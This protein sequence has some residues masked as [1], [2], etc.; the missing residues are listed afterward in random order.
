M[1]G[2][3]KESEHQHPKSIELPPHDVFKNLHNVKRF[4]VDIGQFIFFNICFIMFHVY[5]CVH[6]YACMHVYMHACMCMCMYAHLCVNLCVYVSHYH[7][8]MRGNVQCICVCTCRCVHMHT[9]T[10]VHV[11]GGCSCMCMHVRRGGGGLQVCMSN[12]TFHSVYQI[13]LADQS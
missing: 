1:A 11:L 13:I 2:S 10:C 3:I 7:G 5:M 6:V 12:A 4:A 9:C 8:L